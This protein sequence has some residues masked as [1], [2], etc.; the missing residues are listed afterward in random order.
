MIDRWIYPY[1]EVITTDQYGLLDKNVNS[2]KII[3]AN[4]LL[5]MNFAI[6]VAN[7]GMGKTTL[8]NAFMAE[9]NTF[10]KIDC[11]YISSADEKILESTYTNIT[12]PITIF[13]DQVENEKT[14]VNIRN[15]LR[16][17]KKSVRHC[18]NLCECQV[19]VYF[20]LKHSKFVDELKRILDDCYSDLKIESH[21]SIVW[22]LSPFSFEEIGLLATQK[23]ILDLVEFREKIIRSKL[24]NFCSNSLIA[25]NI[26]Q[27]YQDSH[28]FENPNQLWKQSIN[29]LF[30][31]LDVEDE[32]FISLEKAIQCAGWIAFCLF[33]QGKSSVW[34]GD[35]SIVEERYLSYSDIEKNKQFTSSEIRKTLSTKIFN[36]P[37]SEVNARQF[38]HHLYQSYV[39]A[40]Y[41][42]T[43]HEKYYSLMIFNSELNQ[44]IPKFEEVAAF[45]ANKKSRIARLLL[46]YQPQL[47]ISF[48]S[49]LSLIPP[50][51][52]LKNLLS[53]LDELSHEEIAHIID[54]SNLSIFN[55]HE[56]NQYIRDLLNNGITMEY[57]TARIIINI[58]ITSSFST[59]TEDLIKYIEN[60]NHTTESRRII[61]RGINR[62]ATLDQKKTLVKLLDTSLKVVDED[63]LGAL[64]R[65]LWPGVISIQGVVNHL[66][67]P[68]H[69]FNFGDYQYFLRY[70][71]FYNLSKI[72]LEEA[73]FLLQ[74]CIYIYPSF[75]D[76]KDSLMEVIQK[77]Y[78][79]YWKWVNVPQI[80][81]KY[82]SAYLLQMQEGLFL[83]PNQ[84]ND[85]KE[86]L[87][88]EFDNPESRFII[89]DK[90]FPLLP[91]RFSLWQ[92]MQHYPLITFKDW[93]LI[94]ERI[95]SSNEAIASL[96]IEVI[97]VLTF[98]NILLDSMWKDIDTIHG[99]FPTLIRTSEDFRKMIIERTREQ[100]ILF[101]TRKLDAIARRRIE[102]QEK[103]KQNILDS[104]WQDN[105]Y[106]R[107]ESISFWV[108]TNFGESMG[109]I[110]S[111]TILNSEAWNSFND[112]IQER[113]ITL[114][115]DY[116]SRSNFSGLQEGKFGFAAAIASVLLESKDSDRFQKIPEKQWK[117]FGIEVLN[118]YLGFNRELEPIIQY[119]SYFSDS[120]G[121]SYLILLK[122]LSS[123]SPSIGLCNLFRYLC[124]NYQEIAIEHLFENGFSPEFSSD[125]LI[126]LPK[127]LMQNK[128]TQHFQKF[129]NSADKVYKEILF[130]PYFK[131]MT[132]INPAEF[133]NLVVELCKRNTEWGKAFLEQ[134]AYRSWGSHDILTAFQNCDLEVLADFYIWIE[135][136]YATANRP[137]H[138][139]GYT[140]D[141]LDE[142][143]D[144]KAKIL[145]IF[146][147]ENATEAFQYLKKVSKAFPENYAINKYLR[148]NCKTLFFM[149]DL[150]C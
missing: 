103:K 96:W 44:I 104:I 92:L 30:S 125:V 114:A 122:H 47:L 63:L 77:I 136:H 146:I 49:K 36:A 139:G 147:D 48:A 105:A 3:P 11:E 42:S 75:K 149:T 39:A 89:L 24:I 143:Y 87:P 128:A 70:H 21:R 57:W 107:F 84:N 91:E 137:Y 7:S 135:A 29:R 138:E 118:A 52:I 95:V 69:E 142:I 58:C 22:R 140:P 88:F 99:L 79:Y 34:M 73:P 120:F 80:A 38:T 28:N 25:E 141:I 110:E 131:A 76:H 109:I 115:F 33:F 90:L 117:N 144:L 43:L 64:L 37:P 134:I 108:L 81:D 1:D 113:I 51:D 124:P 4:E 6:V 2:S 148:G 67:L 41:M 59:I 116:L 83:V 86:Y 82:V 40:E 56:C 13:F 8:I 123:S 121:K 94:I 97:K 5:T 18:D 23:G 72:T 68:K 150:Y 129:L 102:A 98:R 101:N 15:Y 132:I 19:K 93:D 62:L 17:L 127:E 53:S 12:T 14:Q 145:S 54:E 71:L 46:T 10:E 65:C 74:W 35:Q 26:V 133:F 130:I 100:D 16:H 31:P 55:D 119:F 126:Q 9:D 85:S 78:G 27:G 60:E 61:L 106:C 50:I 66:S 32:Q 112:L 111:I 45:L 20:F